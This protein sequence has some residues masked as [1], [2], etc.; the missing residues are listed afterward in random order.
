VEYT[1]IEDGTGDSNY[2]SSIKYTDHTIALRSVT[3]WHGKHIDGQSSIKE[4]Y[5][6][7]CSA[8]FIL[9]CSQ[10]RGR[11]MGKFS[12]QTIAACAYR[13]ELLG[14]LAKHITNITC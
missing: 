7:L 8:A 6:D 10:G 1:D 4:K 2:Y 5:P 11:V 12:E 14:L 9:E 13:G 3:Q